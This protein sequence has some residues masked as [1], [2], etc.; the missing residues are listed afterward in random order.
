MKHLRV[1][2]VKGSPKYPESIKDEGQI[3]MQ[4]RE[5]SQANVGEGHDVY[6]TLL[7]LSHNK[8]MLSC[9]LIHK[10]M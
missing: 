6:I 5:P 4:T 2:V 1:G 10:A 7:N 9:K 3:S 8:M